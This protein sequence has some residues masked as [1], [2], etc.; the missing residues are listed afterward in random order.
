MP[1]PASRKMY[2]IQIGAFSNSDLAWR[3]YDRLQ[4][5]GFNPAFE[6]HGTMFRVVIAGQRAA[7]IPELTRRLEAAG[8]TEAWIREEN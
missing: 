1:D 3:C 6:L 8:F 5:A 2:R 4:S 7:N